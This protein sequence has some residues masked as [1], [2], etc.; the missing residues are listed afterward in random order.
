MKQGFDFLGSLVSLPF[1]KGFEKFSVSVLLIALAASTSHGQTLGQA[2]NATNL[3]WTTSGTGGATGWTVQNTTTHDGA[4]AA[5]SG[6]LNTATPTSTLQTITN[7]PGTMTF[8]WYCPSFNRKLAVFVNNVEIWG[9]SG[10]TGWEPFT[11]YLGAGSQT[12]KWVYSAFTSGDTQ[13]GYVDEVIFTPG[14]TAPIISSQPLSQSQVQGLNATFSVTAAGTPPLLY[15]WQLNGGDI[16]GATNSSLTVTNVQ[17]DKLGNYSVAVTNTGGGIVSSNASLGLG[18]VTAWGWGFA[19]QTSVAFGTT[20]VIGVSAGSSDGLALRADGQLLAWGDNSAGQLNIQSNLTNALAISARGNH[21]LTLKPDGTVVALG[22]GDLG[23]TNVPADLSNVVAIAAGENHNL[24]LKAD[25]TVVSWGF[26]QF[27]ATNVPVG[28][29]D[30][31]AIAAGRQFSLVLRADGS[32]VAWGSNFSGLTNIPNGLTNAVAIA[33][34]DSHC[35]ALKGDGNIIGW[36]SSVFNLTTAPAGLSNVVAISA[37]FQ[38]NAALKSDGAIV[39]W[40]NN[41]QGQTNV[42]SGLANV[43]AIAAGGY[44][45]VALVGNGPPVIGAAIS[46]PVT[47]TNS[48]SVTVPSQSGRVYR[49]E[50]KVSLSD[51]DWTALPLVAGNGKNLTLTDPMAMDSQR[52]YRVRRW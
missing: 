20:N 39:A 30:I 41:Q 9:I 7:G 10:N 43:N 17:T 19:G 23:Q 1:F 40:G 21:F 49:L 5:Q 28:L 2:L 50:Y 48:F 44:H 45:T 3:T 18:N 16:L 11:I 15:Q 36:G 52:F 47:S 34:G 37:G 6:Q 24:A 38:H 27:G 29:S 32:L 42:P 31:V 12:V 25:G 13:R 8:W 4:L 22:A 35:L 51:T 33:A 14:T 46:N 26:N